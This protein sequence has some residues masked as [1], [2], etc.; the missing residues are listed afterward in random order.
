MSDDKIIVRRAVYDAGCRLEE[1]NKTDNRDLTD[2]NLAEEQRDLCRERGENEEADF[3]HEVFDYLM[4]LE[5]VAAGTPVEI[6]D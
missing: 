5:C 4:T 1:Q 6:I 3:W 2:W